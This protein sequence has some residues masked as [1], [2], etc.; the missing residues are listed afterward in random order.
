MAQPT[1][2]P[3]EHDESLANH[4][5]VQSVER[6]LAVIRAFGACRS[7]MTTSEVAEATGLN[8]ASAR[9]FLLTL[10]DLGYVRNRAGRFALTPKVLELGYAYLSSFGMAEVARPHL[11][12]FTEQVGE[13]ASLGV[14][15]GNEVVC[16]ARTLAPRILGPQL[17][18]GTRVPAYLT[19][20]GRVLLAYLPDE[21]RTQR[22][23]TIKFARLTPHT[24]DSVA[25]LE[26]AL[27]R[28]REEQV[29]VVDEE[30][31][32]GLR[33]IAVPVHDERGTVVAALNGSG[34]SARWTVADMR[35]RMQPLLRAAALRIEADL[36]FGCVTPTAP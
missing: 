30:L 17:R 5:Y 8:R 35:E 22:L 6:A 28:A 19:S 10:V 12:W 9:R 14:L 34:H 24:V 16:V 23:S 1:T 13:A 11:E 36:H 31:E 25:A 20:M 26:A 33:T 15:E 4:H 2:Q 3:D 27:E 18:I 21:E 29:A 32:E 7:E